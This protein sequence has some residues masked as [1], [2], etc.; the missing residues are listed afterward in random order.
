V[1]IVLGLITTLAD[2]T[3]LRT[4]TLF[5]EKGHVENAFII[6]P[7]VGFTTKS[8]RDAYAWLG[9]HSSASA[10]VQSNPL[11]YVDYFL[12]LYSNRQTVV[13]G[14]AQLRYKSAYLPEIREAMTQL[15]RLYVG[16]E[17][18]TVN[19]D[20]LCSRW[21]I[22]YL[23]VDSADPVWNISNAWIWKVPVAYK[24]DGARIYACSSTS[25]SNL[26]TVKVSRS[27][28]Y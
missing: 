19:P 20:A 14:R 5:Q 11:I 10:V 1:S 24:N 12:G 22:D 15:G 8:A 21:G 6:S 26:G 9:D 28:S 18:A 7:D 16:Q 2:L 25:T 27:V 17:V 23:F 13:G 4:F 3:L